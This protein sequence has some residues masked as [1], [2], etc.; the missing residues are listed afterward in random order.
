[1]ARIVTFGELLLRLSTPHH[2]TIYQAASFDTGFGGAEANVAV[3]MAGW[4]HDVKYISRVPNNDISSAG[5]SSLKKY[6]VN[7][8]DVIF[9]GDRLGLYYLQSGAGA[10]CAEV[11]Y[12]RAHSSITTIQPGMVDWATIL[13]GADIFHWSGISAAVS[14]SAAMVCAEAIAAAVDLGVTISVDLNYRSKLWKY[15]KHPS[16]VMP[17]LVAQCDIIFGG[18]DA[19]EYYFNIVPEGKLNTKG[20]LSEQDVLSICTQMLSRFPKAKCFSSTLRNILNANHQQ[21]QG[22]IYN[23]ENIQRSALHDMPYIVDRVGGGD[24]FMAGLL[25]SLSSDAQGLKAAVDF[26]AASSLLKH[27]IP[28]DFSLSSKDKIN[29]LIKGDG[30]EINR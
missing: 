5:L 4:G 29:D 7:V 16:V 11:I 17:D 8:N 9:G 24:A 20:T 10:R 25:H 18:I 27:Y 26:A 13:N 28:G 15:G 6:G 19:P 23:R 1:M 2:Q 12:D 21:L 22:I 3:A 30:K 14:E